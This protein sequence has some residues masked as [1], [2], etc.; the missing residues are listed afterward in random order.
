MRFTASVAVVVW[1]DANTRWPV[2]AALIAAHTVSA[3]RISPMRITSG[4]WRS[5]IF[6]AVRKLSVS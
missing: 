3:S 2:S 5:T 4:S 6:S 1:S